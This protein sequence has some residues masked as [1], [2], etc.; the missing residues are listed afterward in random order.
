V[1]GQ[2][3]GDQSLPAHKNVRMELIAPYLSRGYS[4]YIDN[5]YSSP[6]LTKKLLEA[7]MN[8]VATIR[9]NRKIMPKK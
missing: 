7:D 5:G 1:S 2:K 6:S 4:V 9:L 3:V 8:V